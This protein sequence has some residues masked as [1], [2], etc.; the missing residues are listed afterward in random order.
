MK[1]VLST[2]VLL[3]LAACSTTYPAVTQYRIETQSLQQGANV[4]NC[5][6]HSL[7]VAQVFVR[8]SLMSKK[9]KYV[10]GRYEEGAYNQSEW[11]EEPNRA[12]T[13]AIVKSLRDADLF[14]TVTSYKSTSTAE[15][16]LESSVAEFTQ[17]FSKDEKSSFVKL[18]ITFMLV[19]NVNGKVLASKR[20]VKEMPTKSADSKGGVAALNALLQ[21]SLREMQ[22]WIVESCK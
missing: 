14:E 13:N 12:L 19:A 21:E 22:A 3:F 8:S 10:V 9:M 2:F 11:A 15:Y 18:D 5:K 4:S 17:H 6:K 1:I 16:A 7:K 20:I